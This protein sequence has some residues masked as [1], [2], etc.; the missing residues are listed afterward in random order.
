MQPAAAV[1]QAAIQDV[2]SRYERG[3]LTLE[4]F[5][6]A[7]DALLLAES[8]DECEAV[9]REVRSSGVALPAALS[10]LDPPVPN[11]TRP[12]SPPVSQSRTAT[13]TAILGNTRKMRQAWRLAEDTFAKVV[14]GDLKL[15]LSQATV[16]LR[17]RMEVVS[18]MGSVAIYVPRAMRVHVV[19]RVV[20]GEVHTFGE[21]T[22]GI[23]S[24]SHEEHMPE[25]SGVEDRPTPELHIVVRNYLGTVKIVVVDGPVVSFGE[26]VRQTMRT[27]AERISRGLQEPYGQGGTP[28]LDKP[29]S[30][31]LPDQRTR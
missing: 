12:T 31:R 24:G 8:A 6:R 14:M 16:P 9:L 28:T 3:E 13:I 15:D 20:L 19:S 17:A 2:R 21:V 27:V 23:V 11:S 4:T 1:Q 5:H 18:V 7:L 10:A 25:G 22:G 26:V 30:Q 29:R